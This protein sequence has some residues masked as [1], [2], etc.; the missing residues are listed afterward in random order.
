MSEGQGM[1]SG[2]FLFNG[3]VDKDRVAAIYLRL[4]RRS[5]EVS[6]DCDKKSLR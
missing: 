2:G 6:A 3:D 4:Q 5:N 1:K